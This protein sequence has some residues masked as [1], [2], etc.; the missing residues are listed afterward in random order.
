MKKKKRRQPSKEEVRRR[1]FRVERLPL[2][3]R[4]CVLSGFAQ[5]KHYD[6]IRAKLEGM[7]V[8][9]SAGALSNY[10]RARWRFE[11]DRVRMARALAERIRHALKEVS[12]TPLAVVGR[13]MLF[14]KVFEKLKELDDAS[15][16]QLLREGRE[17]AKVTRG[18]GLAKSGEEKRLLS[19]AEEAR[20]IRRRWR[21]LY[22]L[23]ESHEDTEEKAAEI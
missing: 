4:D 12:D 9:I 10:W 8:K 13:E 23:E 3:A 14:T 6:E 20:V 19:P 17:L 2:G 15:V 5:G 22:G 11:E 18:E 21:E 7:G 16:W 1:V